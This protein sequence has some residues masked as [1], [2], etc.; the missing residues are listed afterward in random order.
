MASR[1]R[2][3]LFGHDA[4]LIEL[5]LILQSIAWGVHILV[6]A[7]MNRTSPLLQEMGRVLPEDAWGVLL[8]G[9]GCFGF[10]AWLVEADRARATMALAGT[11]FWSL[12]A[13]LL[14]RAGISVIATTMLPLCALFS[15]LVY[16]RLAGIVRDR[17]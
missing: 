8:V 4:P 14:L 2:R 1:I 11:F 3:R 6:V 10:W 13:F 17:P 12:V 16:V 15:G 5:L 9:A 7:D